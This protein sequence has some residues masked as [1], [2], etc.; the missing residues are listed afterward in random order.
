MLTAPEI[1]SAAYHPKFGFG[2]VTRLYDPPD[3]TSYTVAF[4]T[5]TQ[6]IFPAWLY[7]SE[8]GFLDQRDRSSADT[9][10]RSPT[11]AASYVDP[12]A[13]RIEL[14][15]HGDEPPS[16][17]SW[18]VC[19]LAPETG[20]GLL[21]GQWGTGKTFVALDLAASVMTGTVFAGFEVVRKGGVLFVAAEGA[22]EIAPRLRALVDH[23]LSE[24]APTLPLPFSWIE[25]CPSLLTDAGAVAALIAV[26]Q[27]VSECLQEVHCLPLALIVVDTLAAA[28]G[29]SNENEAAEAQ[30]VMN[31][32]RDLSKATGALVLGV[33]HFG[34]IAETGVRGSSAKE[35]AADVVLALLADRELNGSVSNSR[36]SIR[37]LR[38]GKSGAELPF[39]LRT[40]TLPSPGEARV[41]T[42]CI[43]DWTSEASPPTVRDRWAGSLRVLRAAMTEALLTHGADRH[44]FGAE[45]PAV[46]AVPQHKVRAEFVASYPAEGEDEAK[47]AD[48]K[49]SAFNRAL[50]AA[51][52]KGLVA[53][54]DLGGLDH[55]WFT[56]D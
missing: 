37:K 32:L 17:R 38:G 18:L 44:P 4:P 10:G 29:F 19:D 54:R 42:S 47:R 14:H 13:A 20:A 51:I 45:G 36:M 34:K 24:A 53:S 39:C 31:I 11:A 52:E 2:I 15:W 28:A 30:K 16:P 35:A 8:D 50:K 49:R 7:D 12:A 6:S 21:A 3:V 22:T 1:G 46:K 23:K 27:Q 40:V 55:L 48:A 43:V 9:P 41:E 5:G 25:E 26:A 56:T 33:D